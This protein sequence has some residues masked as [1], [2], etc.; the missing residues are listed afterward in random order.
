MRI[1]NGWY[2]WKP[3]DD[4]SVYW[5]ESPQIVQVIKGMVWATFVADEVTVKE[6]KKSGSF[7]RKIKLTNNA[8]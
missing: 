4:C 3:N 8:T 1:T 6:A 7:I 2:E 5:L